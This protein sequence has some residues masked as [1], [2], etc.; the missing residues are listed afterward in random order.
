[1]E[2][3]HSKKVVLVNLYWKFIERMSVQG[4]NLIIQIILTRI[5]MPEDFAA[6]AIITVF[7]NVA[8]ILTQSG[9]GTALMQKE[10]ID[11]K[12]CAAALT[13]SLIIAILFYSIIYI[14]APYLAFF[15][16]IPSLKTLLRL[17]GIIL[18]FGG[19]NAI[20]LALLSRRLQFKYNFF[21][22]L[23]GVLVG[24]AIGIAMAYR[25]YGIYS[26]VVLN[27]INYVVTTL[28]LTILVKWKIRLNFS[29]KRV[30]GLF[31]FGWKIAIGNLVGVMYSNLQTLI[32][33][34]A[35]SNTQLGYYNRGDLLGNALVTGISGA[36][37]SVM[38]PVFSQKQG[39]LVELKRLL[40]KAIRFN[41]FITFPAMLGLAAISENLVAII[42]TDSWLPA[43]PFMQIMCISYVF[44][45]INSI[46]VQAINSLGRSDTTLKLELI[47][48]F[49]GILC[50]G[51]TIPMGIYWFAGSSIISA[52]LS[53]F[54]NTRENSHLIKYA[55]REQ[56]KDISSFFWM[57][58]L[59]AIIVFFVGKLDLLRW[60]CLVIQVVVGISI[61]GLLCLI[62]EREIMMEI[63]E[64]I[65]KS[66]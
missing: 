49:V 66:L 29:L 45:P 54:F 18:F 19:I 62:F 32:I 30:Q 46:N 23:V 56:M 44:V 9:F 16:R 42:F 17:Q 31:D 26:L 60:V 50:M 12:D 43:V 28:M 8:N 41:C 33:G 14:V 7:I 51:I 38:L 64:F 1:M 24:G 55:F 34:K 52:V 58:I 25:G 10:T 35:Y 63:F 61:Y 3:N 6:V 13:L 40:R 36:L 39:D 27:I 57:S 37:A 65:K 4:I 20:Q 47:K 59:M 2:K 11:E 48:R 5:L 21:S 53:V 22:T 15:Y